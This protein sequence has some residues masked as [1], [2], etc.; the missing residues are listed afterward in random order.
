MFSIE[1]LPSLLPVVLLEV[2]YFILSVEFDSEEGWVG[3]NLDKIV[4][5]QKEFLKI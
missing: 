1:K 4:L 3:R 5:D 2:S